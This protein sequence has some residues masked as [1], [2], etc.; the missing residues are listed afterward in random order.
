MPLSAFVTSVGFIGA[1]IV[2]RA[3]HWRDYAK[4]SGCATSNAL[5][6]IWSYYAV[7][8][9]IVAI[10]VVNFTHPTDVSGIPIALFAIM[11]VMA[12]I[13]IIASPILSL[14][15]KVMFG[16]IEGRSFLSRFDSEVDDGKVVNQKGKFII[17]GIFLVV[18]LITIVVLLV[19]GLK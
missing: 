3:N 10:F 7:A 5:G 4:V 2:L 11:T 17:G 6:Q 8:L 1:M 19:V 9:G 16:K 12:I 14:L 15:V 13:D 18:L